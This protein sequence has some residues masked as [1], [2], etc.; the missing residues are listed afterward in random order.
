VKNLALIVIAGLAWTSAAGADRSIPSKSLRQLPFSFERAQNGTWIAHG[1]SSRVSVNSGGAVIAAGAGEIRMSFLG[2]SADAEPTPENPLPGKFNYLIGPD[3][4]RWIRDSPTFGRVRYHNVYDGIDVAWYGAEGGLEY[5]LAVNSGA[6]ASHI[7]IRFDGACSLALDQS[8]DLRVENASGPLTMRVPMVYQQSAGARTRVPT[9]YVLR[10]NNEVGF[11]LANYDKSRPLVIDPTLVYAAWFDSQNVSVTSMAIDP[12]GNIYVGGDASWL[13]TVNALQ[14]G[15]TTTNPFVIKFNP[16]GDTMLY[17]TFVGGAAGG[18]TL[19]GLT[20]DSTGNVIATGASAYAVSDFP[21]VNAAQPACNT[22]NTATCGFVFRL[23][24]TGN[25]LVYSTFISGPSGGNTSMVGDAVAVDTTGN[26]YVAGATFVSK[27]AAAGT[28]QYTSTVAGGA[29]IAADSQGFAYLAGAVSLPAFT[30]VAGARDVTGSQCSTNM[31]CTYV[32]KLSA[33]GTTLSWAAILGG[34]ASQT[35]HAIVRDPNSGI[36]YVAGETTATDLPVTVGVIQPTEH[37]QSDGFLASVS[38]DGSAFGF[39]TYLGGSANDQIYAISLT[40]TGQIVVAGDT[41]S[42][43]FPVSGAIQQAM[44]GNIASLYASTNYGQTW[45]AEGAGLPESNPLT[46]SVDPSNPSVIVA[47]TSFGLFRSTNGGAAWSPVGPAGSYAGWA[48]G[49]SRS[50]ANPEVLY[51]LQNQTSAIASTD[52]G[53]TWTAPT[54]SAYFLYGYTIVAS[55]T[56]A[57]TVTAIDIEGTVYISTDGG[58]TFLNPHQNSRL[59]DPTGP[60]AASPDGTIYLPIEGEYNGVFGNMIESRDNGKTWQALAG[61]PYGSYVNAPPISVC[62]ANPSVLYDPNGTFLYRSNDAGLTWAWLNWEYLAIV[63]PSNCQVL[64]GVGGAPFGLQVSFDGGSTWSSASGGL[65]ATANSAPTAITVDP[66]NPAHVWVAPY[67]SADGFVAKISNDGTTLLWSTFYGGS[68]NEDV[69]GVVVDLSGSTWIAGTTSSDDLPGITGAQPSSSYSASLFLAEIS[70]ATAACSWS[71]SPQSADPPVV[72]GVVNFAVT[73]PSGCTW[74]ATPSD[75]SWISTANSPGGTASGGVA[76][77]ISANTTT[78]PR[79]GTITVG[80]Q[81]LTINQASSSCQY[82]LSPTFIYLPPA[83]GQAVVTVITSPGCPW[84]VVPNGLTIVS[85]GT[86]PGNGSVTLSAPANGGMSY[87]SFTPLIGGIPFTVT[88]SENCT[89]SL[90]P[91]TASG[92]PTE[93]FIN[94]TASSTTCVWSATSDASWLP[95]TN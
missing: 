65:T 28:I 6:D 45:T 53:A 62:S 78:A 2:A 4:K 40:S 5:D 9:R 36:V 20:V 88:V 35:P 89:Y 17:A 63:A 85:G 67:I 77:V 16:T 93:L 72:G 33:D 79:A 90:S 1:L 19:M 12:Q 15:T 14:L 74:S 66:T 51:A 48:P 47:A 26:A 22:P 46:L 94:V 70:D 49:I 86:G 95:L 39:V 13:P 57:N 91:L 61:S 50:L 73:A 68:S 3:P 83:G 69:R 25:G 31:F 84:S 42:P 21:A 37:G 30:G 24:T 71:L 87:I 29:A 64:Y 38:A 75:P 11:E 34:S 44:A 56:A 52:G 8:G 58:V 81:T 10:P 76:A 7:A 80:G 32:A 27:Y 43:D 60:A 92:S 59:P 23:N 41:L 18:D 55:P 82:S 54:F